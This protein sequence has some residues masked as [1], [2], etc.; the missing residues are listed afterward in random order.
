M[1]YEERLRLEEGQA[2]QESGRTQPSSRSYRPPIVRLGPEAGVRRP[3]TPLLVERLV[4]AG[5]LALP[6]PPPQ[7]REAEPE[8]FRELRDA[9]EIGILVPILD[10]LILD[11]LM[12][13]QLC[14]YALMHGP[15]CL[16]ALMHSL[17]C[18]YVLMHSPLCLYPGSAIGD[19]Y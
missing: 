10:I 12:H 17:L 5:E 16:Y 11:I 2:S 13:G 4:E 8:L 15:L 14:L 6:P 3:R 1:A 18:L 9:P 7:Q 19:C